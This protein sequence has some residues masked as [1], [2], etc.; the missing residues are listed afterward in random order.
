MPLMVINQMMM[1]VAMMKDLTDFSIQNLLMNNLIRSILLL[2]IL[3]GTLF[4][5]RDESQK[6]IQIEG[7]TTS[8]LE[9]AYNERTLL[10][11][12]QKRILRLKLSANDDRNL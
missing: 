7:N 1:T 11:I 5:Y 12:G 8:A 9:Q 6:I 3:S 2:L 4:C 10:G